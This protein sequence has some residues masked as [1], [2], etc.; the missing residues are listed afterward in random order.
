[1]AIDKGLGF[2]RNINLSWLD[3]AAEARL[4]NKDIQ[5]MRE[6]L[7]RYLDAEISGNE[8]RRKTIDVLVSIWHRNMEI[9]SELFSQAL[10]FFPKLQYGE[11]IWLH[12]GLTL[13]YYPFF[14][15]TA[16]IIGQFARTGESFTRASIKDRLASELGHL[17]SLNRAAERVVASLLNWGALAHQKKGNTYIPQLQIFKTDNMNLQAWLLACALFSHPSTQ[18]PFSDLI[19]LPELFPMLLSVNLDLLRKNP[20]FKYQRQGMWDMVGK[21]T[22]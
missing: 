14:R 8:S 3:A 4:R 15:Q 17:G 19:R 7:N 21:K 20:R 16:S 13:M 11:R 2:I 6:E 9:D 18:L 10:D 12:Y 5:S 22:Q 1:M